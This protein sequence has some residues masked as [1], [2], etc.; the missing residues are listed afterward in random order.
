VS[1]D[2]VSK[3][4]FP[5]AAKSCQLDPIPGKLLKLWVAHLIPFI[6]KIVNLSLDT[7]VMPSQLKLSVIKPLLK[8]Q[9]LSA[10]EFSSFRPISNLK[11]LSKVIEKVVSCQLTEHLEKNKLHLSL[12]SAYKKNHSVETALLK[13]HNDILSEL[14]K[15][16]SVFLVLLDLSAAFDTVDHNILLDRLSSSFG[17]KGTALNWFKSYLRNRVFYVNVQGG[18]SETHSFNC[19]VPQGSVL[20]PILFSL[21]ISPIAEIIRRHGLNFH[22]YADD[23]QL[24]ISFSTSSSIEIE[25]AKLKVEE[26]IREIDIWM[27]KNKL[28]LNG[29]K[30]EVSV[31]STSLRCSPHVSSLNISGFDIAPSKFV[32]NI[33]VIFDE[34][35]SFESHIN[36]LCKSCFFHINN[37]WKIRKWLSIRSCETLVHALISS[38]LD[39]C[40]SLLYGLPKSLISKLQYVQNS[41]AR[42]ITFTKRYDHI[43]PILKELH[44]LPVEHRIQYKILLITFKAM[45]DLC[46]SYISDILHWY[47]PS[48][49]LRS[50]SSNLL[51]KPSYNLKSFGKRAF[52]F[53]APELWNSIPEHIRGTTSLPIFKKEVKKFLFMKA[54]NIL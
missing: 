37:I 54:Y 19:G 29:D 13:V 28:K 44:W 12:Q 1:H 20:G 8:K 45:H 9:S 4:I 46:P 16:R 25:I 30:T 34:S 27:R 48:R 2:E 50:S 15:K 31:L 38:K 3:I 49:S 35:L 53:S 18:N 40:N 33:G 39:F 14:D 47:V 11:F 21:Y 23:T 6:S 10:E 42:L 24:Y 32:R 22:L 36:A 26:C 7:G 5:M 43:T 52:K 17:V 41:A 51:L